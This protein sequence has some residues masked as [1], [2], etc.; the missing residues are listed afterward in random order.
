[1]PLGGYRGYKVSK[2]AASIGTTMHSI[3]Y[4]CREQKNFGGWHK[5][6]PTLAGPL[7]LHG[8]QGRLLSHCLVM[9]LKVDIVGAERMS[10]GR[11]F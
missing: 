11:L 8:L 6:P 7:A 2:L 9:F 3:A 1:M 5:G 4:Q 10:S